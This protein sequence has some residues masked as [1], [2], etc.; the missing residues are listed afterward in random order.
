M[1]SWKPRL[2]EKY[3]SSGQAARGKT[4]GP[5]ADETFREHAPQIT[6]FINQH[7]PRD[8]S[9]VILDLGCGHGLFLYYLQKL[10]YTNASGIDG[11][12]EQVELANALGVAQ[13]THGDIAA[14]LKARPQ[15]SVDVVLFID[16]LEHMVM[17]EL[18]QILDDAYRVLRPCGICVAHVPNGE[19][20]YGMRIR[21][22]DLTHELS[23]TRSSAEQ[24]FGV[25][26]FT[27]VHC[28][29]DRPTVHGI[30]SLARRLIWELGTLPHRILLT[31][32]TGGRGFILS[33]NLLIVAKK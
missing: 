18:F 10:G 11:S 27:S 33:Q 26:G 4:A 16:V 1:E 23:L 17:P 24:L 14:F 31:A 15:G 8:R 9:S 12:K 5:T 20:I 7:I 32:E 30:I 22:G 6:A 19:G 2:Y 28:H 3:V 29:E 13:V 25:I 21:F